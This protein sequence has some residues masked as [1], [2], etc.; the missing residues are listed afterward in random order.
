MQKI[1]L[2]ALLFTI[3]LSYGQVKDKEINSKKVVPTVST[4]E[5]KI[6][7]TENN[8]NSEYEVVAYP[9]GDADTIQQEQE[10]DNNIYH[11]AGIEVQPEFPGGREILFA[12]ISKNFR[13]TEQMKENEIKGKA[14]ASFIIEKDGSISD[15]KVVRGIGFGTENEIIKVLKSMPKWNPGM[16]NGKK[17]RCS[18]MIPIMIYASK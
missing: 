10:D 12:F 17:V 16:Q 14:I 3:G 8:F 5:E 2:F 18:Y 6:V 15:V 9:S 11:S 7:I 13:Y 4:Q 1:V